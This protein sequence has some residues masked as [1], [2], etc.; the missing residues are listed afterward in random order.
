M[1]P[2]FPV[3]LLALLLA[4]CGDQRAEVR[5]ALGV[6]SPRERY[7]SRL[8][9]A[10]LHE[11][12]VGARWI[13]AGDSAA[14]LA[15]VVAPP[16]REAGYFDGADP[17][18]VA[19]R[20]PVRRGQRAL[21]VVA[22]EGDT[23]GRGPALFVDAWTRDSAGTLSREA[24]LD[25]ASGLLEIEADRDGELV[26]RLQPEALRA[27]RYVLT[28]RVAPLAR[29]FPVAGRDERAAQSFWGAARDAGS[30]SHQGVD[31]FAPRGTPVVAATPGYV[32][33]VGENRLG[34]LV[35]WVVEPRQRWAFYYAHLDRQ[36]VQ[37]GARVQAGDTI[38]LVGNTGNARGTPPH[39]HY[40]IY[41]FPLRAINPFPLLAGGD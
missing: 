1:R 14:R 17:R 2:R 18:A 24:S 40:G 33:S 25:S 30:R 22:A 35:V 34:G 20:W 12:A 10:G 8:R 41:A 23:A 16:F 15:T 3:L 13:A 29:T 19:Y 6:G 4:A 9:D 26:V 28:I 7:V 27:V 5:T 32:R 37:A 38:G 11:T 31:I 39:L 36:L 21:V